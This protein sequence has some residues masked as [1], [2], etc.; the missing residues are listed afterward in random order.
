MMIKVKLNPETKIGL[1]H[2]QV[3]EEFGMTFRLEKDHEGWLDWFSYPT[4]LDGTCDFD[5][6]TRV[7]V[8]DWEDSSPEEI[9]AVIKKLDVLEEETDHDRR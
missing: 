9:A 4:N 7:G 8:R 2:T 3:L 1:G 5:E 6:G